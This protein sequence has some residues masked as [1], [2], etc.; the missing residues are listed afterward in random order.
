MSNKI[1][2]SFYLAPELKQQLEAIARD[3]KRSVSAQ[4]EYFCEQAISPNGPKKA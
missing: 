2:I 1:K 3:S 4:I